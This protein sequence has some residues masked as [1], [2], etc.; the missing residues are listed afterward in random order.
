VKYLLACMLATFLPGMAQVGGPLNTHVNSRYSQA[1][2]FMSDADKGD[3]RAR[4]D[5]GMLHEKGDVVPQN[6]K[7]AMKWFKMSA[8]DGYAP[9]QLFLGLLYM[10]GKSGEK[11]Q[12]EAVKW[13]RLA[14]DQGEINAQS[15]LGGLYFSDGIVTHNYVEAYKWL[16]LATPNSDA[17]SAKTLESVMQRMTP[18]QV[19]EAERLV[20][21]WQANAHRKDSAGRVD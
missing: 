11:D 14:A 17:N 21:Q 6:H 5:V 16:K 13:I 20:S 18:E 4:F 3:A 12:I 7:E 1:A 9:A 19:A 10:S 8:K 15:L 2:R